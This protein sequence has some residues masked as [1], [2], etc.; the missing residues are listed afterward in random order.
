LGLLLDAI[1]YILNQS[2]V[3]HW[4]WFL[5]LII[6]GIPV[7]W[8]TIKGMIHR[9]FASDLV[10]MLAIIAAILT[11]EALPGVV[12]VIMQTGGKQNNNFRNS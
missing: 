1:F 7:V 4:I 10:A 6:G 2:V 11:N 12:I 3:V 9:H 5:T 8:V